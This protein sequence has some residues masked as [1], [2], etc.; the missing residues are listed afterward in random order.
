MRGKQ[1]FLFLFITSFLIS[2]SAGYLK[3]RLHDSAD[4]LTL[5]SGFG[6][7][8]KSRIG[9]VS[10]GFLINGELAGLRGGGFYNEDKS[11]GSAN[12]D[13]QLIFIGYEDFHVTGSYSIQEQRNKEF[14]AGNV[15]IPITP[16]FFVEPNQIGSLS[17]YTQIDVVLGAGLSCRAGFNPG[18]L[19]DFLLGWFLIDIY[20]DDISFS[21]NNSIQAEPRR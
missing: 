6:G 16:Y 10:L 7:G 4:I 3:N 13:V 14:R 17:Y 20:R 11:T 1:L 12:Y 19:A 9:P 8:V 18:E 21:S 5:S 15:I 2:C